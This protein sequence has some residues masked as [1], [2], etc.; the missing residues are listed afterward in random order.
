MAD[1]LGVSLDLL[2]GRKAAE[3]PLR[4]D[5]AERGHDRHVAGHPRHRGGAGSVRGLPRPGPRDARLDRLFRELAAL[6]KDYRDVAAS[7]LEGVLHL[8][9]YVRDPETPV[10]EAEAQ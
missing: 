3:A 6:E 1:A 7:V 10:M 9:R 2:L 4:D 5:L 8:L